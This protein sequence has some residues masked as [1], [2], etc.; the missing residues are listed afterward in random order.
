MKLFT[1]YHYIKSKFSAFLLAN[2]SNYIF[3]FNDSILSRIIRYPKGTY[4]LVLLK[5]ENEHEH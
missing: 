3:K 5:K 4:K 1:I 2:L